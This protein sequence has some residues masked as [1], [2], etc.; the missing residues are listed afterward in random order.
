MVDQWEP[1]SRDSIK[2]PLEVYI[3]L[4]GNI[5]LLSTPQLPQEIFFPLQ[6]YQELQIEGY[7][8][9]YERVPIT[10]EKA[11]KE[12]DFDTLVGSLITISSIYVI[13]RFLFFEIR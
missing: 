8:V 1:V 6:V 10:D 9:D 11:P 13:N 2:T 12:Q 4:I 5:N 3:L 7:L